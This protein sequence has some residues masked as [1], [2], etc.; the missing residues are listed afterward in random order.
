MAESVMQPYT[1]LE[2]RDETAQ[3]CWNSAY[4]PSSAWNSFAIELSHFVDNKVMIKRI[5]SKWITFL[6]DSIDVG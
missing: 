6:K 5:I 3:K 2:K 1:R 4:F